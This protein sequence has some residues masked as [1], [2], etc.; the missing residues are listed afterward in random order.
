M[1][2]S[3]INTVY[4]LNLE[5]DYAAALNKLGYEME[6]VADAE[7]DAALGNGGLG[8]L[9][10]C[11]LD[12]IATLDLP[13]W[14]YGIRYKYGMFKQV[15]WGIPPPPAKPWPSRPSPP[16]AVHANHANRLLKCTQ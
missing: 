5:G 15:R 4:N 8:R 14:G 1:G 10:A 6:A 11:F 9:A 13:G 16:P 12:S 2:R 7:R 3:L